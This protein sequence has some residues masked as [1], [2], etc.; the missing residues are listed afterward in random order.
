MNWALHDVIY[1]AGYRYLCS[2]C[3]GSKYR[4]SVPWLSYAE[5]KKDNIHYG[6][7]MITVGD[8]TDDS[9]Q[10]L[11]LSPQLSL[12]SNFILTENFVAAGWAGDQKGIQQIGCRQQWIYHQRSEP[13]FLSV[14]VVFDVK[15]IFQRRWSLSSRT[16]TTSLETRS[17]Q[18]N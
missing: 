4:V 15:V 8:M 16:V 1:H 11:T 2:V 10:S 9:L 12:P 3:I 18:S 6:S 5:R 14:T 13:Y 7:G 17:V